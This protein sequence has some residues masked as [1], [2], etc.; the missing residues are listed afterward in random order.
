MTDPVELS[1]RLHAAANLYPDHAGLLN[2]TADY[3][4]S[5]RVSVNE[6]QTVARVKMNTRGEP[7]GFMLVH[8][9]YPT[10][11]RMYSLKHRW[12][13]EGWESDTKAILSGLEKWKG[14]ESWRSGFVCKMDK[15][16]DNRMW[17]QE[18]PAPKGSQAV[19]AEPAFNP[20]RARELLRAAKERRG[21]D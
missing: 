3:L 13:S 9:A 20:D 1:R 2:E 7:E 10:G 17:E 14:S 15:F 11:F 6:I 18:P 8:N 12:L 19:Q 16:L 5:I 4:A 21:H